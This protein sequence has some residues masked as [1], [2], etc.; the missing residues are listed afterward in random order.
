MQLS[1]NFLSVF[2]QKEAKR[3]KIK[4][5]V[6]LILIQNEQILLLRRFQTGIDDGCYVVPMGGIDG[7]ETISSA[8]IRE[9]QEEANI[10]LKPE[11]LRMCHLM[12]RY[13]PMPQ[14]LSFEQLD[15]FFCANTYKGEI[16]NLEPHKCDELKFYPIHNLPS[17]T[18]PFIRH[19]IECTM[20]GKTFSEFGWEWV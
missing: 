13:H 5:G 11:D 10:I 20:K 8:L 9:A 6:F 3:F 18:A 12:H 1:E 15:I 4:A 14:G 19:A 2:A 16:K 17:K 7:N